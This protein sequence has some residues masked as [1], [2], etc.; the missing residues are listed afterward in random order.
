MTCVPVCMHA[1]VRL[2]PKGGGGRGGRVVPSPSGILQALDAETTFCVEMLYVDWL[3]F[4]FLAGSAPQQGRTR[5]FSLNLPI[6]LKWLSLSIA[7]AG[8]RSATK[9]LQQDHPAA[10]LLS[11][12]SLRSSMIMVS[13]CAN[14]ATRGV[15]KEGGGGG[16]S[17]RPGG[18][19]GFQQAGHVQL[20]PSLWC[21]S[22]D[23]LPDSGG[24]LQAVIAQVNAWDNHMGLVLVQNEA[25][26]VHDG[27]GPVVLCTPIPQGFDLM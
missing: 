1:Y 25:A 14:L 23:G 5:T 13:C 3:L 27:H 22:E 26:A 21:P 17:G 12:A 8:G 4:A 24:G 10:Q 7:W 20:Q 2:S 16:A 9:A 18:K 19:C 6:C 11:L 15:E